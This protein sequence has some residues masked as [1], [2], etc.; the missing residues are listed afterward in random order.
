MADQLLAAPH[1]RR[2]GPA[3]AASQGRG[4]ILT[5]H[6]MWCLQHTACHVVGA[7]SNEASLGK[8]LTLTVRRLISCW[9]DRSIMR[10]FTVA[11]CLLA[12]P[13]LT[14]VA[15]TASVHR[16]ETSKV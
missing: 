12:T 5:P 8:T 3:E 9:M 1:V 11:L 4:Q 16:M 7:P 2:T 13:A 14:D 15:G 6:L 10:A